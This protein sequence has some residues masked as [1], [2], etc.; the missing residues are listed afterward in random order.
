MLKTS[1]A[2]FVV[3]SFATIAVAQQPS[4]P[5]A[6]GQFSSAQVM[7]TVPGDDLTVTHWYK[8]SVYDPNDS[9]I[10]EVTDVLINHDGKIDAFIVAVGGFLGL[11]EKDVAVPFNAIHFTTKNNNKWYMVMNTTKDAMKAAPGLKYDRSA[12]TWI[13]E[14][15]PATTGA[16]TR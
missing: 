1:T 7:S 15:A 5:A 14:S 4:A 12:M 11:G 3:A 6:D 2:V 8:E 10:G 16:G 9:K 13:A